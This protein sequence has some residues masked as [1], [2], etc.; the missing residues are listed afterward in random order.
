[1]QEII[2]ESGIKEAVSN[3]KSE[4][5]QETQ[6]MIEDLKE[7]FSE[8]DITLEDGLEDLPYEE[9]VISLEEIQ[10]VGLG[11]V[12]Q[13]PERRRVKRVKNVNQIENNDKL[14]KGPLWD[15]RTNRKDD[16]KFDE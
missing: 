7:D 8:W 10:N 4:F 11:L 16:D 12:N 2:D 3:I 9:S 14:K 5:S 6:A 13:K 15:F 1:M